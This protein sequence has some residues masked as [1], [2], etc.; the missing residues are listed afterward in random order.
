MRISAVREWV[1]RL[2]GALRPGESDREMEE[3]LRLHLD[4]AAEDAR[5]RGEPPERAVRAARLGAG[6][7]AQALEAL[8]D[9]RGLP[10][11]D[12]LTRDVRH[13][14]R[15]LVRSPFVTTMAIVSLALGIGV[16][17]AIVSLF[18][19]LLVRPLPVPHPDRLV[20]LAAPGPKPGSKAYGIA[21]DWDAV[22]SY[23]MFRDLERSQPAF[24]GVAGHKY[25]DVNLA[26]GG[27]T[28]QG[29]GMLVSGGYFPVLGLQPV[30]GRLIG[31]DDDRAVG[32]SPVA[33]LSHAYW[34]THFGGRHDVI[35]RTLGINGQTMTIIGIAP[36]GF[37]GTTLGVKAQVFVP[38]TMRWLLQANRNP[39][40]ANRRSY[41]VYLFARLKPGVSIEQA[42][43]ATNASYQA[44]INDVEVPL[45]TGMSD[46]TMAQ[47]KAK[48]IRVEP[49]SRGQSDVAQDVR[50][51]LTLLLGV[52]TLVLLIAC[53]NIANLLL[54]RAAARSTEMATRLS[55][56]ASRWHLVAQLLT[57]SSLLSVLGALASLLVA[58]GTMTLVRSL[59]PIEKVTLP[60]H[61][62]ASAFVA[63]A[64]LAI[65]TSVLVGVFPAL[66]A[67]RADVLPALKGQSGQPSGG[68][69]S[70]RFRVSLATAQ[71]ALSMVLVVLALLFTKS[72]DN[73][74]DVDP[75]LT[76]DGLVTFAISPERNGYASE[77]SALLVERLEDE[78][79]ALPG[80]TGA[81]SSMAPLLSGSVWVDSVF[82]EGFDVGPD[83]DND[84]NYD[85]IGQD[86]FHV[87][88]I[89]VLAG[90][91]FTRADTLQAPKVAIVNEQFAEKFRL[92]RN[93][94]GKRMSTARPMLDMEI[95]GLVRDAR[96]GGVKAETP[97]MVFLPHRQ[98]SRLR[99][100]TFYVRTSSPPGP[101]M[102]SIRQ[103]VSRIDPNLPLEK[104]RTVRQQ[105]RDETMVLERLVGVLTA[106]FA[107]LATLLAA[108]G[109]YG[110]LAYTIAQRTREIG[111]RMALGATRAR[112]RHM[113]LR[114]VGL[115]TLAG[116]TVG[117]AAAI[118]VARAAQSLLFELRSHDPGV[119]A[120]AAIALTLVA[121]AAGLVP[122]NRAA[123]IDPM[124]ALRCE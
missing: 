117:L 97:P 35:G 89:P 78:L 94:V 83:T 120:A 76:L 74:N 67:T 84:T 81:T 54:A 80:V 52:T 15:T 77:R 85:E 119:L 45:H 8:R 1:T 25:L 22:F 112:V 123:R 51:P 95:V 50:V 57:E 122:A 26:D 71:I 90:R 72:L 73:I 118:I 70:A 27:Y 62:D 10:W 21:G 92:G 61:A 11:L 47:F 12:N 6:G 65:G 30:L 41:W 23:P 4:L 24:V 75:G 101:I 86:Y 33:V 69:R 110:V 63:I 109:L 7:T 113:V 55:I 103:V 18:Y 115:M 44:I 40:H 79:A 43:A 68:R 105:V 28:S 121:L 56:G 3:E 48:E 99:S 102:A 87:L 14:F 42:R 53:V 9:Q 107:G 37:D 16:N 2:L 124:R 116:G 46:Q 36:R 17:A 49:G 91:E 106:A 108:I 104:L 58:N 100:M 82:V 34:Q 114:Q 31:P 5:R 64:I 39:D 88:D 20:N 66:T 96:H 111:L 93:A 19:Q 13:S 29:G 59:V 98:K 32:A 38:I 60:L